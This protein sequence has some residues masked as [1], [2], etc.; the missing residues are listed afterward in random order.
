MRAKHKNPGRLIL[1]LIAAGFGFGMGILFGW[2]N[3]PSWLGQVAVVSAIFVVLFSLRY[4]YKLKPTLLSK[5]QADH[6][7][8]WMQSGELVTILEGLSQ[9]ETLRLADMT[10]KHFGE[11]VLKNGVSPK[12][13][14]WSHKELRV[15]FKIQPTGYQGKLTFNVIL[16]RRDLASQKR[17]A[18][19]WRTISLKDGNLQLIELSHL[20]NLPNWITS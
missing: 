2:L 17:I 9:R 11:V 12:G 20:I 16:Y 19:P 1:G 7:K 10:R 5:E 15:G 6:V 13:K 3:L 14:R 4:L 18:R 8:R